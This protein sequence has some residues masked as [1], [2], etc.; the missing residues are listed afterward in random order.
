LAGLLEGLL[1][2]LVGLCE[3]LKRL[4]EFLLVL[5]ASLDKV[6]EFLV[7]LFEAFCGLCKCL[8]DEEKSRV[9]MSFIWSQMSSPLQN[10]SLKFVNDYIILLCFKL[11]NIVTGLQ[12]TG[13]IP[14]LDDCVFKLKCLV[15]KPKIYPPKR[16]SSFFEAFCSTSFST[17]SGELNMS[18]SS[19]QF[20]VLKARPISFFLRSANL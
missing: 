20:S 14:A 6:L 17:C 11:V 9:M 7:G 15:M 12:S 16:S 2:C 4:A 10:E 5:L 8:V 13:D 18:S 19:S 3:W 1:T